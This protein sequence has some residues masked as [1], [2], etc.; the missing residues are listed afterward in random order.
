MPTLSE[1]TRC[2]HCSKCLA[3][4]KGKPLF[5]TLLQ[6][7]TGDTVRVHKICLKDAKR[8]LKL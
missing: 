8:S 1:S 6:L 7:P 4:Q 5:F 3:F 2:W